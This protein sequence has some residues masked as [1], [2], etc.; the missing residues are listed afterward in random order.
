MNESHF[1]ESVKEFND[2]IDTIIPNF[3]PEPPYG[4]KGTVSYVKDKLQKFGVTSQEF[5]TEVNKKSN[6]ILSRFDNPVDRETL[7]SKL[8][9]AG[10]EAVGK[11]K[12]AYWD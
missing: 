11:Y 10:K 6:E 3:R 1:D 4:N 7:H 8:V 9:E 5:F 12:T 2:Y